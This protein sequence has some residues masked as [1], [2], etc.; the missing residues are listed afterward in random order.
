MSLQR[1]IQVAFNEIN[2]IKYKKVY[3]SILKYKKI[4]AR[5]NKW[6]ISTKHIIC[7]IYEI[8]KRLAIK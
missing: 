8:N 5:I 3:K 7:E 1:V 4:Y 2:W 6:T